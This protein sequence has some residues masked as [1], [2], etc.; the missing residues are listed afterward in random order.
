MGAGGVHGLG[1]QNVYANA[2]YAVNSATWAQQQAILAVHSCEVLAKAQAKSERWAKDLK[3]AQVK[4]RFENPGDKKAVEYLTEEKF[5]LKEMYNALSLI[6]PADNSAPVVTAANC[7]LVEN[8]IGAMVSFV[9]KRIRKRKFEEESYRIASES[10]YGWK[11]EKVFRKDAM[12]DEDDD[13]DD[14][15]NWWEKPELSVEKKKE[16]V[17]LAERD[18]KFGLTNKRFLLQGSSQHVHRPKSPQ[19]VD[20]SRSFQPY[21]R[22][23]T[24]VCSRCHVVG[25]IARNCWGQNHGQHSA[26]FGQHS[27]Q[28]LVPG[29]RQLGHLPVQQT[30]GQFRGPAPGK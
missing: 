5:D 14:S 10:V 12:F 1:M 3:I 24:R 16:K 27:D 28:Q 8:T 25:H 4:A 2:N 7:A 30:P 22:P 9:Q 6:T 23:D 26:Q 20:F 18:V 19:V 15:I 17:R 29:Q 13:L 21:A 11:T